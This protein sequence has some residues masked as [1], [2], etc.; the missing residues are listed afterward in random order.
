MQHLGFFLLLTLLALL[1]LTFMVVKKKVK[2]KKVI[3]GNESTEWTWEP[4]I[5]NSK[6]CCVCFCKSTCRAQIQRIQYRVRCNWKEFGVRC[7][8]KF[9]SWGACDG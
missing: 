4:C 2:V 7:K 8:Y 1:A 6:N 5:P 9:E 3:P